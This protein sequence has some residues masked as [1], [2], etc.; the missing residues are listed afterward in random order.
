[1][2][3]VYLDERHRF[4]CDVLPIIVDAFHHP[5][6]SSAMYWFIIA[7]VV[8]TA[9]DVAGTSSRADVDDADDAGGRPNVSRLEHAS[10]ALAGWAC[11]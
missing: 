4:A 8:I 11:R 10:R 3:A 2:G 7:I 1:M 6:L 9:H 5:S